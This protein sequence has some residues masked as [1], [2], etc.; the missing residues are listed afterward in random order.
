MAIDRRRLLGALIAAAATARWGTGGA[1]A[2]AGE[3]LYIS[4]RVDGKGAASVAVLTAK[5]DVLLE[6]ALP[7]RGHD[8]AQDPHA[9]RFVVFARR[10]GS[11]AVAVDASRNGEPQ[12][13]TARADRHFFGHGMYSPDGRLLYASENDIETGDGIIGIYDASGG[14]A[15]IGEFKSGGIGPHDLNLFGG[16]R[17]MIIANGGLKTLPETGRE[18]LNSD[19]IAPNLA[20]LDLAS[21]S[22]EGVF[23]LERV[24]RKLSIRH[25]ARTEDDRTVFACQHQGDADE[26][27]PLVGVLD[28]N[29]NT[30]LFDAPE[31]A[32]ARLKNYVGSVALDKSGSVIAATSPVGGT[33]ALWSID[34]NYLGAAQ[35]P[36]VCGVARH[37]NGFLMSSGNAG[38]RDVATDGRTAETAVLQNWVWDNHLRLV[39]I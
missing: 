15:R 33:A 38:V 30:R 29:G 5:G 36:D 22:L 35:I 26:L 32:L 10:P 23:E 1:R 17:Q 13:I 21:G 25:L 34:G 7:A 20:V 14:Y 39:T 2:L 18:V 31:E 8:I 16:G 4:C 12:I 6:T 28:R 11:W 24:Y 27:P 3:A 9:R 19:D 37:R